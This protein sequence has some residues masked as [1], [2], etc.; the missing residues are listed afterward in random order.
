M[1]DFPYAI[2]VIFEGNYFVITFSLNKQL[3][4]TMHYNLCCSHVFHVLQVF[5]LSANYCAGLGTISPL[6]FYPA[7]TDAF[8]ATALPAIRSFV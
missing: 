8:K 7:S 6:M 3:I 4:K 2:M 5:F 1:F